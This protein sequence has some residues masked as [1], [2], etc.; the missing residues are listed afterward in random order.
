MSNREAAAASERPLP[1]LTP[2]A[3]NLDEETP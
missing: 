2:M 3:F 1:M